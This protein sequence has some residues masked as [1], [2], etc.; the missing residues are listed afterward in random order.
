MKAF[1]TGATG[2]LG[3]RVAGKLRARGDEVVA[4][5]RTRAKAER[6]AG[7]GCELVEGDLSAREALARATAGCDAVFHVAADYRIGIAESERRNMF[8][9][10]VAGTL[11]V[12][13]AASEVPRIVYVSTNAVLGNT[14]GEVVD[15]TYER[16]EGAWLSAYDE[17]KVAARRL[18]E[19]RIAKGAPVIVVQP[20]GIYGPGD[21]TEMGAMLERAFRGRPIVLPLGNV[22]LN[23]VH[24]DD[25]A[26]G[27]LLAHDRGR[28]GETYILG[29]EIGTLRGAVATAYAAGGHRPLVV[30]VPNILLRLVA[31]LGALLG[32]NVREI[33]SASAGVTY[34]G[35]DRKARR[36]LG[37][38]PR[39][40]LT[41]LRQ[42]FAPTL[43]PR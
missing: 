13:D 41:G 42:T 7:L 37:Y 15:E 27:I 1:V 38:A 36:E 31:P 3:G 6:L 14:H 17:S 25:V 39:D 30:P 34:W 22:G 28:P 4:L 9:A 11:N 16:P 40:L 26:D 20:G 29:G 43:G 8:E 24:V 32:R 33:L 23:W 21:H 2:F 10:N 35:G 5:V 19:E 12:L 18:V